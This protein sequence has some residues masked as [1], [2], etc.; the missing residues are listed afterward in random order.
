MSDEQSYFEWT[1]EAFD[2][3]RIFQKPEALRG[4]RV[5]ELCTLILGPATPDYL[6][7]FGAEVIKVELPPAGDTMRYVPPEGYF[8]RNLCFGFTPVNHSK[9]HVGIDLHHE[10]GKE[11]FLQLVAKSD[12]VVENLRAGGME[13]FG[14]GYRQLREINPRIIVLAANGF[15]QWGPFSVGRASYDLLAQAASG[16]ASITGFPGRTPMKSGIYIGD[17]FGALMNA[18]S[19]LAALH[20]RQRMG[21]G[22]YIEYSQGEGLIR[23]LDWTWVYQHLTG[24]ERERYGNRDVAISP[25]G[26]FRCADG[27]VAIAAGDDE[28]FGGL[29]TAM[30][31]P[32]LAQDLRFGT[33]KS[34]LQAENNEAL[35]EIV[36]EWAAGKT[37]AELDDLGATHGFAASPVMNAKDHYE[38]EH[39]RTR[40]SV[41]S[42]QDPLYGELTE[43]G[44]APKLSETP[45]RVRWAARPVGFHNEYVFRQLLGLSTSQIQ[46]L[47]EQGIVG[48]WAERQGAMP[49]GDWQGEGLIM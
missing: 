30:G 27:F 47:E 44:P 7:E 6:A 40:R 37:K 17:F 2:P 33:L 14:L 48:Q 31:R 13:A 20:Y 23:I 38:S 34:R 41:W 42:F 10:E 32:E 36:A 29:C 39:L 49:P 43:Y 12:V 9:Y 35:A 3:A 26:I 11:L 22:Q 5:I 24:Q 1:A 8:W 45:G 28:A 21:K 15:G 4:L 46:E 16:M 18:I 25:S 19:I